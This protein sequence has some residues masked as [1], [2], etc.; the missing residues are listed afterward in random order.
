MDCFFFSKVI[1][2]NRFCNLSFTSVMDHYELFLSQESIINDYN[3][4]AVGARRNAKALASACSG[5]H[6]NKN[7]F[8]KSLISRI[9]TTFKE[10]KLKYLSG[11]SIIVKHSRMNLE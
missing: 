10:K 9:N 6:F 3:P 7:S 4:L 5:L 11:A 2:H 1:D 8:C